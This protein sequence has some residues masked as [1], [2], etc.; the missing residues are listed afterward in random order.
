MDTAWLTYWLLGL[1]GTYLLG[2]VPFGLLIGLSKGVDVRLHGSKNIGASNVGRTIGRKYGIITFSLDML[3]G[4]R[5]GV[6]KGLLPPCLWSF[7]RASFKF[8]A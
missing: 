2:G 6:V 8:L 1:L 7:S 4:S 3:K 5:H